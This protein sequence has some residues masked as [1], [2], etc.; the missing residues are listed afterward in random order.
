MLLIKQNFIFSALEASALPLM[1]LG[2]TLASMRVE[3]DQID[4]KLRKLDPVVY[5]LI[6]AG[7]G[8]SF[9]YFGGFV[10]THQ[11]LEITA[12]AGFLIGT[13]LQAKDHTAQYAAY[14]V[15]NIATAVL[16]FRQ[17]LLWFGIQQIVSIVF[18]LDAYWI[19]WTD[20]A[21][22]SRYPTEA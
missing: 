10:T 5:T 18:I 2:L 4:K 21:L 1:I 14:L 20:Q 9:R 16:F 13:Y 11:W 7:L 19:R 3:K 12:S 8:Y 6:G 15:M 17:D 22:G